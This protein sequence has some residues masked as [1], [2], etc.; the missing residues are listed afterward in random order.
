MLYEVITHAGKLVKLAGGIF[1]THSK[2]ADARNEILCSYTS[3][4]SK[5]DE[6]LKKILYSNTTE[7]I[8]EYLTEKNILS[9]VFELISKRIVERLSLRRNN[10]V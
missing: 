10:F 4:I 9:E 5:D 2:V 3:M 7:E 6:L 8:I 1:D